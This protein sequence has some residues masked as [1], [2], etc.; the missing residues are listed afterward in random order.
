MSSLRKFANRWQTLVFLISFAS[1]CLPLY[2][3]TQPS[4]ATNVL[5]LYSLEREAP[6]YSSFDKALR[7][8]LESPESYPLTYYTEYLDLM[9]FPEESQQEELVDFL[10][11]KYSNRKIDLVVVVSPLAL[12]FAIKNGDAL[13]PGTPIVFASVNILTLDNFSLRQNITGIAVKRNI[14]DTLELA[15]RLQPDTTQVVV[16]VGTSQ[17][18]RSW[19]ADL[20]KSLRPYE[21]RVTITFLSD[22]SMDGMLDRLRVLPQHTIVLF[23]QFL[24]YDGTGR[25]FLP[26]EALDLICQASNA[27]VYGT[28]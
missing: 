20:Q 2:A 12:K 27:P 11:V 19:T 15:L 25:Y 1:F 28:D 8:Q 16:P 14:P 21:D 13:F 23:S 7:S 9:R 18:E 10:R 22:L 6:I 24:F 26:E 3:L 4:K 5:V 17:L